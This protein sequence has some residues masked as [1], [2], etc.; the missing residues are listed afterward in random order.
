MSHDIQHFSMGMWVVALAVV[1]AFIGI[2]VG[3]A[4]ARKITSAPSPRQRLLWLSWAALSIAGIG[5]WLPHYIAMV[6][7]EVAGSTVRYDA[8]WIAIS[9]AV[10]AFTTVL[11]L[12]IVNPPPTRHRKP[13]NSME[14]GRLVP[15]AILLGAGFA[16]MHLAIVSSL[17]IQGS[18]GFGVPLTAAAVV[19]GFVVAAGIMWSIS[20]LRSRAPRMAAAVATAVALVAMH[21]VGV[22]G[23]TVTVD[24]EAARSDGLEVFSILFPVFVLG[25]FVVTVPITALLMAPD[26]I[27]AELESEADTLAEESRMAESRDVQLE[28]R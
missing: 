8:F 7:L 17:Q 24:P 5:A 26:R 1:T 18:V 19:I 20:A 25:M 28:L 12:L 3:T 16:G 14:L 21:Y 15:G 23:L 13:S 4:S 2:S 27:A 22:F 9:F 11:A 10:P 6:G